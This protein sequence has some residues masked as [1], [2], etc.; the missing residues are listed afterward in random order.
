M[1]AKR[2]HHAGPR[3]GEVWTA[4]GKEIGVESRRK[5]AYLDA[6]TAAAVIDQIK[7]LPLDEQA[8]VIHAL[9]ELKSAHAGQVR[10]LETAAFEDAARRVFD[11]HGELMHKLAQ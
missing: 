9:E 10:T 4:T 6:V 7:A 3:S 8:K 11:R 1:R 2:G 5:A